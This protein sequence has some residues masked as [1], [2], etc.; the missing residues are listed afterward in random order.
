MHGLLLLLSSI[1]RD[2]M[3]LPVTLV[4]VERNFSQYKRLLDD[5][6]ETHTEENSKKLMMLYCNGDIEG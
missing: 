3:W 4:D 2:A 1:A 5:R 6:R